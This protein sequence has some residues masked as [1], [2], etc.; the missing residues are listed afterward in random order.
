MSVE[1]PT[2]VW[3]RTKDVPPALNISKNT[4]LRRKDDGWLQAGT[5]YLR[6][7]TSKTSNLLWNV[8]ACRKVLAEMAAPESREG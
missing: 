6:T 7:G 1:L 5:H 8:D 3:L 4:L 2:G